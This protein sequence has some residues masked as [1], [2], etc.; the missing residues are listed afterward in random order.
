MLMCSMVVLL[1][2]RCLPRRRS[3]EQRR[4]RRARMTTS[5]ELLLRRWTREIVLLRDWLVRECV[6]IYIITTTVPAHSA[7]SK[8]HPS[9]CSFVVSNLRRRRCLL[10]PHYRF[11][12][13]WRRGV[14]CRHSRPLRRTRRRGWAR[15]AVERRDGARGAD[16]REVGGNGRAFEVLDQGRHCCRVF[17]CSGLGRLDLGSGSLRSV[18]QRELIVRNDGLEMSEKGGSVPFGPHVDV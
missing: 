5:R 8:A 10:P 16:G 11:R 18:V 6:L 7:E 4:M 12:I 1:D 13:R 14:V 15:E 17:C 2:R 3:R 9:R